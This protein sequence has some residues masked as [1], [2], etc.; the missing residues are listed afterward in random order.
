M[1]TK[2]KLIKVRLTNEGAHSETPWAH[3]L[4]RVEGGRKVKLVNV[5]FMHA[6]PTWGDTIVVKE[7]KGSFPTWDRG[8]TPWSKISSRILVDGGRWAMIVQYEPHPDGKDAFKALDK[9]CLDHDI[10]CE[11][12]V[13]PR[14]GRPGTAYLAVPVALSDTQVMKVLRDEEL[15]CELTQAHPKPT[16]KP[17]KKPV[18]NAAKKKAKKR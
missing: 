3:D 5:P 16:A 17:K 1:A 10:I 15:P 11:G 6:K 4:G 13:G 18:K 14:S 12:A 2:P 7:I 8:G 9:A